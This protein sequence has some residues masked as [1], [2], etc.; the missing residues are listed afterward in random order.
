MNHFSVFIKWLDAYIEEIICAI[1]LSAVAV[2]V[3]TQ[4]IVR[5][6]F[7]SALAW[8]EEIAIYGMVWAMYMGASMC[9]R[10]KAHMRILIGV[11]ALPPKAS[12]AVIIFADF[13]WLIFNFF[14]VFIGIDYIKLLIEQPI[15]SPAL[16]VSQYWAQS[17]IPIGFGLMAFRIIE[18]YY[19]WIKNGCSEFPA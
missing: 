4:F 2:C 13:T 15:I 16:G 19:F 12:M 6:F 11:K 14:M 18:H 1:S 10:E 8:P 9:V 17:I 5:C 7:G 3:F